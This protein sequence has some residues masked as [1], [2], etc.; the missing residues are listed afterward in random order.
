MPK[1]LEDV[2]KRDGKIHQVLVP[3]L[4]LEFFFISSNCSINGKI[5]VCRQF[6]LRRLFLPI[7]GICCIVY[8][9]HI[10]KT[11]LHLHSCI[12]VILLIIQRVA[13]FMFLKPH[14]F[15]HSRIVCINYVMVQLHS[16]CVGIRHSEVHHN[17]V[18]GFYF[19]NL[20]S[21]KLFF[22]EKQQILYS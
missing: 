17:S 13:S 22:V 5:K 12:P 19:S 11:I 3:M 4:Y 7:I 1:K 18:R 21:I 6:I 9:V 14:M 8:N 2:I 15:R 16:L 20:V 10:P